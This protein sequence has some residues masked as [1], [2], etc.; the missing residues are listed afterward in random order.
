M[1]ITNG[2]AMANSAADALDYTKALEVL[3]N[4]YPERDGI[5]VKTLI[6]SKRNGGLTYNDFLML[7]GYIGMSS[8]TI[9]QHASC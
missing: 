4:E 1:P 5:D 6:D 2:D 8:L 3:K 7:P 9:W